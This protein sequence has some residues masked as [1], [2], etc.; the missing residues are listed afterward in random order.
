MNRVVSYVSSVLAKHANRSFFDKTMLEKMTVKQCEVQGKA[1]KVL[2]EL[3]LLPEWMNSGG[4]LHGGAIS[5]IIDQTT[6]M[7]IAAV[8]ERY[9]VSIDLSV[10]FIGAVREND[11]VQIE[12]VCH[13]VG[14]SLAF[15]SA[16]IKAN[17]NVVATGKHTKFMMA[18]KTG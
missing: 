13:K 8:D 2:I 16:E 12:A 9:T 14:K 7:A 18:N 6:T 11:T 3:P 5:T 17:G 4:S 1:S 15:T 10:S